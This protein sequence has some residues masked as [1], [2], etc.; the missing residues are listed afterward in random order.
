MNKIYLCLLMI[1]G[2]VT[3]CV[4]NDLESDWEYR[5]EIR[6]KGTRS[7]GRVGI[8]E[9]QDEQISGVFDSILIDGKRYRM[10]R[11]EFNWEDQG[12][13]PE[14]RE[15]PIPENSE[16]V[17]KDDLKRGWYEIQCNCKSETPES[18]VIVEFKDKKVYLDPEK[19]DDLIEHYQLNQTGLILNIN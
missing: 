7:E 3:G 4:S 13:F 10:A 17:S 12:Y 11:S 9:Y 18:W 19:I 2:S 15:K 16:V 1:I 5:I 8:L 6:N 14:G